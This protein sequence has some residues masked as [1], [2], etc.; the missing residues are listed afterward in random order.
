M[1]ILHV[2]PNEHGGK[3]MFLIATPHNDDSGDGGPPNVDGPKGRD[4]DKGGAGGP[5]GNTPDGGTPNGRADNGSAPNTAPPAVPNQDRAGVQSAADPGG[6]QPRQG[7]LSDPA[8]VLKRAGDNADEDGT[9][10][11]EGDPELRDQMHRAFDTKSGNLTATLD[12]QLSRIYRDGDGNVVIRAEGQIR[13]ADGKIVG[14]FRREMHPGTGEVHNDTFAL[15]GAEQGSG[16]AQEF[17]T[18]SEPQ[19]ADMGLTHATVS[20]T[21]VGG[22]AWRRYGWDPDSVNAK[23]DVPDRLRSI[24]GKYDLSDEDK[25]TLAGWQQAFQQADQSKWPTPSEIGDFGKGKYDRKDDNGRTVWPGKDALVGSSWQGRR[26]LNAGSPDGKLQES[27]TNNAQPPGVAALLAAWP[28]LASPLVEDLAERAAEAIDTAGLSGLAGIT[29]RQEIVQSIAG[30]LA[31]SM[32]ERAA[33]ASAEA[34]VDA[35]SQGVTIS[36][37]A[38]NGGRLLDIA[39]AVAGLIATGYA[40]VATQVALGVPLSEASRIRTAITGVASA[41]RTALT[42]LGSAVSGLVATQV[43]AALE[44]AEH[45][46]R[47]AVFAANPPVELVASEHRDVHAC[48]NCAK[49]NGQRF[50]TLAEALAVYPGFGGRVDCLGGIRCRG[51]LRGVWSS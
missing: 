13:N 34:V 48:V 37:A 41:V 23:G 36:A 39:E 25:A 32:A 28:D 35:A 26:D 17:A 19:L 5:S 20:A 9:T 15:S 33:R 6:N 14:S 22:Y 49:G 51:Q 30:V 38:P 24:A 21:G 44:A 3:D 11:G 4:G 47:R 16:F 31:T 12:D 8:A 27:A 7:N 50:A 1:S 42:A 40:S 2:A 10:F 18:N 46:G 43:G 45:E 29:V